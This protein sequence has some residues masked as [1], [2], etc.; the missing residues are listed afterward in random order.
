MLMCADV[1]LCWRRIAAAITSAGL[2]RGGGGHVMVARDLEDYY[3]IA[4][5]LATTSYVF[6]K[7][8]YRLI[9]ARSTCALYNAE[10]WVRE[11]ERGLR[12]LWETRL[13]VKRGEGEEGKVRTDSINSVD[14][15][16]A[17]ERGGRLYR[18]GRR[19]HAVVASRR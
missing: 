7:T 13:D 2:G 17:G 9:H 15:G 12:M 5:R 4:Y 11:W 1:C 16:N 3:Q 18:P 14:R 8:R 10:K 19:F 6:E